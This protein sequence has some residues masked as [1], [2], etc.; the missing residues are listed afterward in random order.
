MEEPGNSN[1]PPDPA[2]SDKK[3]TL[4]VVLWLVGPWVAIIAS[5]FI[6]ALS[7][8]MFSGSESEVMQNVVNILMYLVGMAALIAIPV[9]IVMAI[10][11]ATKK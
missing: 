6:Y 3:K 9:G 4:K 2:N 5:F 8:F 1:L 11:I 10:L 7:N